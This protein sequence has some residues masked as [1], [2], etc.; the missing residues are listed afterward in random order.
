MYRIIEVVRQ[1]DLTSLLDD[2]RSWLDRNGCSSDSLVAEKET[3]SIA[4][5][6]VDF[7]R[8]EMA[9]A[10]TEAFQGSAIFPALISE[11]HHPIARSEAGPSESHSLSVS[12][13]PRACQAETGL[14]CR[15]MPGAI[16]RTV[17]PRFGRELDRLA[18]WRAK[19]QQCGLLHHGQWERSH[20]AS[21]LQDM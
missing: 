12:S 10:F 16:S 19:L 2:I 7:D 3:V 18:V 13:A 21:G 1:V 4:A 15:N 17:D 9:E 5:I 8:I 20:A 11:P 6:K 14:A